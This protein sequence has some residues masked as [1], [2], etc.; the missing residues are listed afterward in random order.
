M[1]PFAAAPNTYLLIARKERG[2]VIVDRHVVV[3]WQNVQGSLCF[4]LTAINCEMGRGRKGILHSEG[5][6]SDMR[7]VRTFEGLEDWL[8]Y[9]SPTLPEADP[10]AVNVSQ[11]SDTKSTDQKRPGK[12]RDKSGQTTKL[13]SDLE[14]LL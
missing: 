6:V 7:E 10:A 11:A 3:G 9:V 14:C 4:P 5:E 1:T 12:S 13:D 8:D 2:R